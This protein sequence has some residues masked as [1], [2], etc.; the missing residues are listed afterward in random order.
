MKILIAPDKFKHCLTARQVAG[1]LSRGI[2]RVLPDA[3]I[4][5]VPMADGGEGTVQAM[6]DATKGSFIKTSVNNPLMQPVEAVYGITGSGDTA[7]IEMSAASGLALLKEEERNPWKTT[8]FGTGELIKH[9]L[10]NHCRKIIIGIGGSATNDA[11]AGMAEALGY[12]FTDKNGQ[13][14]PKG[15]GGLLQVQNIDTSAVDNRI[16][17]TEMLVACDVNNPLTGENG[18]SM[19]Y[20]RQKGADE[21]LVQELEKNLIHFSNI[22]RQQLNSDVTEI[23]GAGAAGGLGAGMM[24]FCK[25]QLKPGFQ[26]IAETINLEKQIKNADL[27]IT[28]EGKLDIQTQYGKTPFGVAQIARQHQKKVIA[29]GGTLSGDAGDLYNHGFDLLLPI[30]ERPVKLEEAFEN[31]PEFLQ[32]TGER[33]G[34]MLKMLL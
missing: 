34:R 19:V 4:V 27:V 15:G 8:T 14:I 20:A 10:D 3:E 13:P 31:A 17:H 23:P 21:D 11:G 9:A 25:A 32:N 26:V 30:I 5:I 1:N 24:A 7:V 22:I 28:G 33:I 18:A 12:K 16:F 6:V 2:N 29:I